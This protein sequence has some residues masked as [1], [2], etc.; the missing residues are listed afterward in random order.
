MNSHG[1]KT[2]AR[3]QAYRL[4]GYW[5]GEGR[6]F[7]KDFLSAKIL[8]QAAFAIAGF[9]LFAYILGRDPSYI[10]AAIAMIAYGLLVHIYR[11]YRKGCHIG[12]YRA[13][14]KKEGLDG[15]G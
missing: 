1:L 8:S 2:Y 10:T 15:K 13:Q 6:T 7:R 3:Y 11:D 9:S 4:K 5:E 12:W 14:K